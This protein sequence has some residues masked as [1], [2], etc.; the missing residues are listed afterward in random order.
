MQAIKKRAERDGIEITL[1]DEDIAALV[2][3][4][5]HYC[6]APGSVDSPNGIDRKD[7][8]AGYVYGNCLPCCSMCNYMKGTY[9]Y[10]AFIRKCNDISSVRG[11]S[12]APLQ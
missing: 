5:C 3:R 11:N 9:S 2:C 7:N 4:N 8:D 6:N 10:W 12:A 1:Q